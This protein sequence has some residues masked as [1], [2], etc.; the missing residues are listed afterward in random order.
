MASDTFKILAQGQLPSSIGTIYT[1]PA[2][3]TVVRHI[4]IVNADGSNSHT[5]ELTIQGTSGA[6]QILPPITILGG[7]YGNW[8][9][10]MCLTNA[11]TISGLADAGSVVTYTIFGDEIN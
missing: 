5:A 10:V 6:H 8:D 2:V 9:G 4:A 3:A 1:C 11:Q 7:G